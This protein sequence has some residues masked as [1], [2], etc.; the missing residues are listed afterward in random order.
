VS[1][2]AGEGEGE[3]ERSVAVYGDG[4]GF[5]PW[6]L[7]WLVGG[8]VALVSIGFDLV[9]NLDG[10]VAWLAS[11]W[12]GNVV[13]RDFSNLWTAGRLV[14]DHIPAC[15]FDPVCFR[16]GLFGDLHLTVIQNYS[17]PPS[18]LFLAVPFALFPYYVALALWTLCGV[19]F[20]AW[21]ARPFLPKGF[22]LWLTVLTPAA[23][24]NIWN[25]QYGLV[26]GGLWLL[27]FHQLDRHPARA[28]VAAGL[29]TFKPHLGVMVAISS[30]RCRSTLICA[31][32]TAV[33]L[34]LLS[35]MSFGWETWRGFLSDT[36][37]AQTR[38]LTTEPARFYFMMMPSAYV[39]F[40]RGTPGLIAQLLFA[41]AAVMLLV[42][43]RRWDA[44]SAATATF[45]IVPYCFNY[46]M[47]VVCLGFAVMLFERW[48]SLRIAQRAAL[49]LAFFAPELV[50]FVGPVV[51]IA[52][53]G[54][55][56]VQLSVA[57][58][59]DGKQQGVG[60]QGSYD[61]GSSAARISL[62]G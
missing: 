55:L 62:A 56:Q 53:L 50:Y 1:A 47:T 9:S 29:L 7:L 57:S 40:G 4:I 59:R 15:A 54:A 20:F 18:A 31:T 11:S 13:G 30:L 60:D 37:A 46:D 21:A 14:L 26:V 32:V 6:S 44:F 36:T 17:Y 58:E 61:L 38:L 19:C 10:P 33:A 23:T 52:L 5:V 28:G 22:P 34:V 27:F 25:G 49:L 48:S 51:P 41:S 24:I 12:R 42:R 45:L 39:Q 8:A 43:C 16:A 2:V 3:P 35:G